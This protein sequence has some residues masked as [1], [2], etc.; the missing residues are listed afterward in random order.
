[1]GS[2]FQSSAYLLPQVRLEV[3]LWRADCLFVTPFILMTCGFLLRRDFGGVGESIRPEVLLSMDRS[4]LDSRD[5][6]PKLGREMVQFFFLT[7]QAT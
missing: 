2:F 4:S 1:M 6:L 3:D 7:A 5:K